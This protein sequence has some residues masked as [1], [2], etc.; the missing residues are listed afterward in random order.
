MSTVRIKKRGMMKMENKL[1]VRKESFLNGVFMWGTNHILLPS[2]EPM[3]DIALP[4]FITQIPTP[5]NL[6]MGLVFCVKH[7]L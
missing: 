4:G 1:G 3:R 2:P 5:L 7:P 6:L